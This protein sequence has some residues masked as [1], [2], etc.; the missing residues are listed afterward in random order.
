MPA[1]LKELSEQWDAPI[2]AH[3]LERP[4]LDGTAAYPPP[5][6]RSAAA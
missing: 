1:R 3:E 4:Y 6:P 5:D 2:Y